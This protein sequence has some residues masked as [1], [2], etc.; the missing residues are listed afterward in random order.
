MPDSTIVE[1][2]LRPAT[3][4]DLARIAE[5][6][7][8]YVADT[9]ITFET[10]VPD[11]AEWS[12]RLEAIR[13]NGLPFLVA[14]TER[15]VVGYAYC[16]PWKTRSAYRRTAEDSIYL[17]PAARGRGLGGRLLDRL[18]DEAQAVGVREVIAVIA[19]PAE[20]G[21]P[22]DTAS[23]SL[24]RRRGFA[25]AGRLRRVG[26]K[27]GHWVDTVLMQRSLSG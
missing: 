12:A 24:H 10:I 3:E 2:L 26:H 19:D 11:V 5:I 16:A 23:V 9:V 22:T 7:A 15:R 6:Y 18:L 17:D 8:P 25:E 13:G 21:D 20:S 4:G 14:E 27:H 1:P